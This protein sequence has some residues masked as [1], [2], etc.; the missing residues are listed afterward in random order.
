MNQAFDRFIKTNFRYLVSIQVQFLQGLWHEFNLLNL[1]EAEIQNLNSLELPQWQINLCN[2]QG[3][4]VHASEVRVNEFFITD[5]INLTQ[6]LNDLGQLNC[7]SG[8]SSI[9]SKN[10]NLPSDEHGI[11]RLQL[12]IVE[13][14]LLHHHIDFVH[15]I[16]KSN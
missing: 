13:I 8:P 7:L 3:L 6:F 10:C 2:M 11:L 5:L 1:I 16:I 14:S 12:V 9:V 15:P 4:H